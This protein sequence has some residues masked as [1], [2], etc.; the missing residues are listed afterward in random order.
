M[1]PS[2]R[3]DNRDERGEEHFG[4]H[5]AELL[6]RGL[7]RFARR[8][9]GRERRPQQLLAPKRQDALGCAVA[10]D[11]DDDQAE[12]ATPQSRTRS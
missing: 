1:L 5:L 3:V 7:D 11:V 12:V 6:G 10:G 2:S 4:P 8:Y 9:V